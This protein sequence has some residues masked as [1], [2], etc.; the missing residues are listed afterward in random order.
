MERVLI[1]GLGVVSCLGSGTDAFWRGL[2]VAPSRPEKV[3]GVHAD[4]ELPL[5]YTVADAD[6]PAQL[7]RPDGAGLGRASRLAVEAARQ[8]VIDAAFPEVPPSRLGIVVGT[9]MGETDLHE[10]WRGDPVTAR[11][12]WTRTFTIASTIGD[13]LGACGAN[14]SISNAC[15]AGGY[16]LGI[17]ADM[18]RCG[19][20][21][22]VVAGGA[23]TYSY[24][25]AALNRMGAIDPV[26]CRPFDLHRR[27][28][29]PGEGAALLV[30]ESESHAL[31][32]QVPTVYARLAGSGWSCD[33]RQSAAP[34]PTSAQIVRATRQALADAGASPDSI[35]CVIPHGT[36]SEANDVME[37]RALREVFGARCMDVP[38]YSLKARIGHTGGGA[39]AFAVLAAA[40]ILR[41]R[42]VP[43]NAL[44]DEQDPECR[45]WI[46]QGGEVPLVSERVMVNAHASGGNGAALILVSAAA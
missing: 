38:L 39:G 37:S 9:L 15:A 7:D 36:G 34:E 16:A 8:A 40:L 29:S 44:L 30:F 5:R 33:A 22:V 6:L 10:Q 35:G 25:R 4:M 24:S 17:A 42:V 31:R 19:E 21:D 26:R 12:R 43:P 13:S 28:I 27:G 32:R 2:S 14:A 20:A 18:I 45:V 1:T 11:Q 3:R 23:D 41:H 46:P